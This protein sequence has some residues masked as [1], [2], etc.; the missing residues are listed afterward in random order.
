MD[1]LVEGYSQ[2]TA[3]ADEASKGVTV[4][5]VKDPLGRRSTSA[6]IT[7]AAPLQDQTISSPSTGAFFGGGGGGAR[8]PVFA[9]AGAGLGS[10]VGGDGK[11]GGRVDLVQDPVARDALKLLF[12]K[13]GN[14][15][16]VE[17]VESASDQGET[18]AS[19]RVVM[20]PY[21]PCY[22]GGLLRLLR[23]TVQA[24]FPALVVRRDAA[25]PRRFCDQC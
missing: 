16:Q 13:E 20:T 4:G 12:S 3:L 17:L 24:C 7:T 25:F 9:A 5:G 22:R 8:S 10:P 21:P 1:E 19:E 6:E 23:D 14:Y 15:V 11:R 2:F 18:V